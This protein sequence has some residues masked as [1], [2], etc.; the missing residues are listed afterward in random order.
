MKKRKKKERNYLRGINKLL[1]T[2]GYEGAT[3]WGSLVRL[4]NTQGAGRFP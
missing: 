1:T 3:I 4:Q 2:V